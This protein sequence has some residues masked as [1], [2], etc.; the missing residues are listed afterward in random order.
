MS[1]KFKPL[2]PVPRQGK[3]KSR[4]IPVGRRFFQVRAFTLGLVLGGV[5]ALPV[6]AIA[7]DRLAYQL[8][9]VARSEPL[10]DFTP[11]LG[12]TL[13]AS[14]RSIPASVAFPQIHERA[15]SARVPVLM[16]HDILPQKEVFFDVTP[17]EL[18]ADFEE[19]RQQG[20]TPITFEQLVTHLRTGAPLPEKPV[21]LSFDDGYGGHHKYV[22]RLMKQYG[23]P[24]VFSIYTDKMELTGGRSSVTWE[25]LQEMAADPL[26]TIASHSISHPNDLRLLSDE[27]LREEIFTSKRLLEE[28][29]G[30][31]IKY[32][33]YPV[34]K[35]DDRVEAMVAE[36]GYEAALSMDDWDERFANESEDILTIARFGQSRLEE[37]IPQAWGGHPLPRSDGGY[38][39]TTP[40]RKSDRTIERE[41][42]ILIT[43]G[44]PL[45]IHADSRYQVPEII[46]P[47]EAVAAVDGAF[48]SLEYL[49]SNVMI[50]PILSSHSQN[51]ESFV[52]GNPGENP[53]LRG[54]PLVLIA[55]DRA[56]FV[57]FDPDRHN[58]LA[59]VQAELPEVTD[60]FVGAGWLVREGEAQPGASFGDLYGFDAYRFRAFWG[61]NSAGQ[62][63]VGVSK[64]PIDSVSLG[65]KLSELGMREAIMLDSG[66]STSLAYE[67]E[68]LVGFTPRP[69]P[70]VV[71]LFPPLQPRKSVIQP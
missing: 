49:D 46:A 19:I 36:A 38:D 57:P 17:T 9:G 48:F 50:G 71:A 32:F 69:V 64:R 43:G 1:Q 61:I 24:A 10:S 16:Y 58:T 25:Q 4:A 47:T 65:E 70:H 26:V 12:R 67:G 42:V 66:A 45:T 56:K 54:R 8:S 44:R 63:V 53:L 3:P 51:R 18:R 15:R 7:I 29:L 11:A 13:A 37:V 62:P 22:Y 2:S 23:Y 52:P 34:G 68:S 27:E 35:S 6:G 59:G 40:I 55:R 20:L 28:R 30:I 60:A 5:C 33:T 21:L 31:E 41:G 39:F 14:Y